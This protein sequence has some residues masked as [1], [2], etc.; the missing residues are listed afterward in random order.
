ME[1]LQ[2]G[3]QE[4]I[5]LKPIIDY[6]KYPTDINKMS[7]DPNIQNLQNY[8]LDN[9]GTL[10]LR[11]DDKKAELREVEEV[12]VMPHK[13]QRLA[14]SIIHDTVIGGRAAA[15]RTIFAAR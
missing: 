9:H 7:V 6:L 1:E 8:F 15:E 10:F 11:I 12:L 4:D 5:L 13:L 14:V 3:Q 2:K